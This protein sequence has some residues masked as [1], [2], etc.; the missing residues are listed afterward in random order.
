MTQVMAIAIG[1]AV[2]AV[3]RW[4]MA[5]AVQ[6]HMAGSAFPW[7]TFCVNALGSFLLGFLFVWFI[8]RSSSGEVMRMALTVGFLGAFTTFS[9]YSL[10]SIRLLEEGAFA[11]AFGNVMG[12]VVVGLTLAWLGM[13]IARSL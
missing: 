9:T 5:S 2:G 6:R 12:Q 7:G 1:G 4:L 3:M 11:L 13:S 10:E 8:E